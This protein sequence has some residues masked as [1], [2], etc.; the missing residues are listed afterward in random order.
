[1]KTYVD[2]ATELLGG[3]PPGNAGSARRLEAIGLVFDRWDT[4]ADDDTY[5]CMR[6]IEAICNRTPK[7]PS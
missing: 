1:M 5:W 2:H 7:E 3:I 6:V 4:E